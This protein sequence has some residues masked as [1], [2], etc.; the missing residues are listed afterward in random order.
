MKL[1]KTNSLYTAFVMLALAFTSCETDAPTK[2]SLNNYV[3]IETSKYVGVLLD[4]T[5]TVDTKVVATDVSNV[6]RTFNLVVDPSSTHDAAYYNVPATVT[7]PAG[8]KVGVFQ[9]VITGSN[10]GGGKI[11][12]VGLE[13]EVGVDYA[14]TGYTL[15]TAGLVT[16]VK[17]NKVTF[18]IDR[19]CETGLSK[20]KLN[21]TF[22]NYPEE[23]AWELYD[24]S[25]N[26]IDSG[27]FDASGNIIGYADLFAD[28][29][30]FKTSFCLASGDY[31]FVMYDAYGDGMYTSASV[32]GNY[33]VK[34]GETVLASGQGDFGT[35][36]A[37]T[38]NIP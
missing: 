10:L 27:G 36:Q 11:L 28:Q 21:I 7:I 32:E 13:T 19:V 1:L 30:T 37:T 2:S 16:A 14:L 35:S 20:V 6:D 12:V 24:S 17:A 5:K 29:S 25:L 4:Q 22:D 18:T 26:V 31:T 33:S 8:Q 34:L 3:G 9:T 38:F 23:T 15:D